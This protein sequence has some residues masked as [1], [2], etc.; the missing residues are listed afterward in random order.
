MLY[1]KAISALKTKGVEIVEGRAGYYWLGTLEKAKQYNYELNRTQFCRM[2]IDLTT[3][4]LEEP[5]F[6]FEPYN[7]TRD[8]KETIGLM[9]KIYNMTEEQAINNIEAINK[10][11][12][13]IIFSY[14]ILRQEG[15]I[16]SRGLVTKSNRPNTLSFRP[17][18]PDLKYL[19][20]K[21]LELLMK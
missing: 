9:M 8:R 1:E 16:V 7:D 21:L 4:D 6:P 20:S 17:P 14:Q 15:K 11:E 19:K 3:K 12:N 10:D 2:I 18:T 5:E 13:K